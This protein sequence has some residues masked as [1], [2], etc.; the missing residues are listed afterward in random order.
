MGIKV[1]IRGTE[2]DL[3]TVNPDEL[4]E[5]LDTL[6]EEEEEDVQKQIMDALGIDNEDDM[7]KL[8]ERI[9][10]E[11]EAREKAKVKGENKPKEQEVPDLPHQQPVLPP[12]ILELD[13]YDLELLQRGADRATILAGEYTAL[14]N[15]GMSSSQAVGF[16]KMEREQKHEKEMVAKQFEHQLAMKRIEAEVQLQIQGLKQILN[17]Q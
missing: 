13:D 17:E 8:V 1:T 12:I 16:L 10:A 11:V 5:V 3:E 6:T 14:V 2:Y 7:V 4:E 9:D 15:A